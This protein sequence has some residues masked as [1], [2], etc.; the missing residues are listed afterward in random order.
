MPSSPTQNSHANSPRSSNHMPQ[1]K[2]PPHF[3][4]LDPV[5]PRITCH[6][7]CKV[8]PCAFCY[9]IKQSHSSS[10]DLTLTSVEDRTTSSGL[11]EELNMLRASIYDRVF[12]RL[13]LGGGS[14]V[15]LLAS[16]SDRRLG[17]LCA[18][19]SCFSPQHRFRR[20]FR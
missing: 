11:E 5:N 4:I 9:S 16:S 15:R 20:L 18:F 19:T 2:F 3:V 6:R 1:S 12:D 8:Y 7:G 17:T 14:M 13:G 10:V